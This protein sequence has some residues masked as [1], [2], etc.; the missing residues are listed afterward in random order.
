MNETLRIPAI[1]VKQSERR[2]LYT[3]AVDGKLVH[4]FATISRIRRSEDGNL[5]G[6]QRPE[7]L[8]HIEEIRNYVESESP[9]VPNAV[10]IAFDSRVRFEPF[11]GPQSPYSRMGELVVPVDESLPEERRPGF[12]VDGQQRLAAIRDANVAQFPVCASG[13][14]TDDVREQTEQFILVNSTKPLPKGLIYE[15]LPNTDAQLPSL[16]SRRKLPSLLLTRLNT[17]D[18][19][20]LKGMIQTATT[21]G[22]IIKDNS[23]LKMLENS[24]S[25]GV[26]YR[27]NQAGGDE[28]E[29]EQ[30][31]GVLFSFWSAVREVFSK[32]WGKKPKDSRLLHGAGVVSLGF[33]M[34]AISE[35]YR[36][37]GLPT[38]DQFAKDLS[39]LKEL[40]RWSD[41]YWDFGQ[42]QQRKWDEIQN[43]KKD[44]ALLSN[45]LVIQYKALV[46]NRAPTARGRQL[47]L[48]PQA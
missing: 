43:T 23:I 29:V 31:L 1:E 30:I 41:G 38:K 32:E 34:D 28:L 39:P 35:R 37:K 14:I 46:W 6:Y 48:S 40:C 22:G 2:T 11:A 3:F 42:N 27:M 19:S 33:L 15:L 5:S 20:P 10:V 21:P 36:N 12:I 18:S 7:V 45:H 4:R 16:L 24:L 26:L 25:D 8:S 47:E 13:F 44:I 17:R 9:M